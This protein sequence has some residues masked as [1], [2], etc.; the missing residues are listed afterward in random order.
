[1]PHLIAT[2][3]PMFDLYPWEACCFRREMEEERILGI[4]NVERTGMRGEEEKCDHN[5]IYE[6]IIRK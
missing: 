2:C 4:G 1:M 5:A 6:K 3:N